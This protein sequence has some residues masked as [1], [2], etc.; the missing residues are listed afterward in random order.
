MRLKTIDE[1]IEFS[2]CAGTSIPKFKQLLKNE[3]KDL[4]AHE[5]MIIQGKESSQLVETKLRELFEKL[6]P[7]E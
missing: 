5:I 1:C 3:V 6:F 7:K 4:I 2:I